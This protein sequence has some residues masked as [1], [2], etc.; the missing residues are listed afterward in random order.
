MKT[1]TLSPLPSN[2]KGFFYKNGELNKQGGDSK[3]KIRIS[4][5][6]LFM[7]RREELPE[8]GN[9]FPNIDN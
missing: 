7:G 9:F 4:R 5:R 6:N 1:Y 3:K 2:L 8:C